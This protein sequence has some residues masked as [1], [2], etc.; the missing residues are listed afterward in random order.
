VGCTKIGGGV[1]VGIK[2]GS[3]CSSGVMVGIGAASAAVTVARRA[4]TSTARG[5]SSKIA[6]EMISRDIAGIQWGR[7][8]AA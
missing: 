6:S 1:F 7:G 4:A 3:N 2:A 5:C 8:S